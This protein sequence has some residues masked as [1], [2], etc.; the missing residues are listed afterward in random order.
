MKPDT[1]P[2]HPRIKNANQQKSGVGGIQLEP[3]Q[4]EK[5][6]QAA[7]DVHNSYKHQPNDSR[8]ETKSNTGRKGTSEEERVG[9]RTRNSSL[10]EI[11]DSP[12]LT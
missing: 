4:H 3:I 12:P 8:P 6:K 11:E 5:I 9:R 7:E 1:K 10:P 2:H